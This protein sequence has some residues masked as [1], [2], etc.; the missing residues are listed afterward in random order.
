[1]KRRDFLRSA[2]AT[3]LVG[4]PAWA[5]A[6]TPISHGLFPNFD[7][8]NISL[9]QWSLHRSFRAG[10][11]DP[12]DFARIARRD[13]D[14]DAIEYVNTFYQHSP[15][16]LRDLKSRAGDEGVR[17][18]LIMCDRE[19]RLGDPEAAAR[20]TAVA[21]HYKWVDAARFLDCHS[22]RVNAESV[23]SY[24]EQL[25][26]AADGLRQLTE[27]AARLEINVIVENHGGLSS[28]G[29]W[30]AAVIRRVEHPRCGTLP[31]FGNFYDYDRYRGVEQLMPFAKGVSAKSQD[32]DADGNETRI[33]YARM[34][35]IVRRAGYRG[36]I[37]IEYEGT[38]LPEPD[39]IRATKAL[40][41]RYRAEAPR[42]TFTDYTETIPNST[43]ALQMKAIPGAGSI[44]PFWLATTEVT[45]DAFLL[46][47]YTETQ[48]PAGT[49]GADGVTHPTKPYG[50]V[51]RGYGRKNQPA[52][53]M[54]HRAGEEFCVWL[55]KQTGRTYR[56]PTEAEWEHAY[57]AGGSTAF[58]WGDTL[59][60]DYAWHRANSGVKPHPVATTKPNAW[61]LYDMAGNLAEWCAT[62]RDG[63]APAVRG[64]HFASPPD[65]LR[66][67]ARLVSD[68]EAWNAYDP[69][70]PKS[71]WW[72]SSADFVGFRVAR[73]P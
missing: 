13:F 22:I 40:L 66:A 2:A 37:G 23:G 25:V 16:L 71:V 53:G 9:A 60:T 10:T 56:L 14:I 70:E 4:L 45:W 67:D 33:D 52:L 8:F 7:W 30:L 50:D 21:N 5:R 48:T 32:F 20:R 24:D 55:S 36:Y 17:S 27:Y 69:Q 54:S 62:P 39:G 29:D 65:Q 34:L 31:D 43:V 35:D 63:S 58:F 64:G 59:A 47:A 68:P 3:A 42:E 18:L 57:R 19:G 1:M 72:L 6:A 38:R 49:R 28:N 44:Q 73:S 51:Y 46:W 15:A 61:G 41:E 11:L 26:L 12:L